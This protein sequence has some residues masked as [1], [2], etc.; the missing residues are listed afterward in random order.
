MEERSLELLLWDRTRGEEKEKMRGGIHPGR[1]EACGRGV[2]CKRR[3][4]R[5]NRARAAG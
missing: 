5:E 1:D 3:F 2:L 4:R